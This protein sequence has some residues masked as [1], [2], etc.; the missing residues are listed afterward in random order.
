MSLPLNLL[1]RSSMADYPVDSEGNTVAPIED[2][3]FFWGID[4]ADLPPLE[5]AELADTDANS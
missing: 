4:K 3:L 1:R 2:Q 5:S